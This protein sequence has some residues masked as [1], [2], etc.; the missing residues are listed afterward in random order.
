MAKFSK[1]GYIEKIGR[2]FYVK[3]II[4]IYKKSIL[5]TTQNYPDFKETDTSF[6]VSTNSV[7][8]SSLNLTELISHFSQDDEV[9]SFLFH[10]YNDSDTMQTHDLSCVYFLTSSTD[11]L[12]ISVAG[13]NFLQVE[14]LLKSLVSEINRHF[15]SDNSIE[16]SS[17]L[18]DTLNN[19]VFKIEPSEAEKKR[20]E[21]ESNKS[22]SIG[23]IAIFVAVVVGVIT[24]VGIIVSW[25]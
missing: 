21:D 1:S 25:L 10:F 22:L 20:L 16:K 9:T 19:T 4:A 5:V 11:Q 17:S 12:C 8:V 18:F 23:K 13:Q 24:L 14:A 3:D 2:K 6:N 15:S 7:S